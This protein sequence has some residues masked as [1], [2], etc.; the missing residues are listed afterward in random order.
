[1]RDFYNENNMIFSVLKFIKSNMYWKS[2]VCVHNMKKNIEIAAKVITS[3]QSIKVREIAI[4]S[5]VT[6]HI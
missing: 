2:P 4:C 6:V 1:M 5:K 3:I